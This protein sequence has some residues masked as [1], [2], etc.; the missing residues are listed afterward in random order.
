MDWQPGQEDGEGA[1]EDRD[2]DLQ[3]PGWHR[4]QTPGRVYTQEPKRYPA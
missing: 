4:W 3:P 1:G 2:P